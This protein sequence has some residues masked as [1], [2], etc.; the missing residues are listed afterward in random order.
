MIRVLDSFV[1]DKIAAGEVIEKPLSIVKELIENSIDA[2]STSIIVEIRNGGKSYIRITDNGS[3]IEADELETAFLR[4][5][6]GKISSIADLDSLNTLGFR[7][8]AL[9]S[10]S[11]VSRVTVVTK[12]EAALTGRKL[13][14]HGGRTIEVSDIG[15]NTGTTMIIEDVFYN[16][17]ARRKFMGSDAREATSIIDLV[18]KL[19]IYYADI[20]FMLINNGATILNTPG[21]G[22]YLSAITSIYKER[23]FSDLIEISN[24]TVHGF[25][26]DPATTKTNRKGQIF[27]VN[28]RI[29]SSRVIEKGIERGY[30]SRIFSGYP[31]AVLFLEVSPD[32]IDVN[33]HPGKREIKFLDEN[34]VVDKIASAIREVMD[35]GSSVA[36][37]EIRKPSAEPEVDTEPVIKSETRTE[38]IIKPESVS[39]PEPVITEPR[40]SIRD[41]LGNGGNE[42]QRDGGTEG[43]EIAISKAT[44]RPFDFDELRYAGYIFNSYIITEARDVIYMIDQHAAHERV[45]YE[46]LVKEYNGENHTPQPILTPYIIEVSPLV[47]NQERGW[48]DR[49]RQ[50]GYDIEDFGENTFVIRGIPV[51]MTVAEADD[52]IRAFVDNIG[53]L[54]SNYTVIDKLI[55]KSCKSAV[56][57]NNRLSELEIK[58]LLDMLSKC[59]N[60]FCCPHGRPTFIKMTRYEVERAFRRV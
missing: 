14:M 33:I 50:I 32:T 28:G 20:R 13:V 38:S 46:K 10:I 3:G 39:K 60:P 54:N 18:Q 48:M 27:F 25:I 37:L 57:A 35:K 51:Y 2:G 22:N 36:K 45:F 49:V 5:A 19:A 21:N 34:I 43:C 26:S 1:A 47:Y 55:M 6:T 23:E 44:S 15:A 58:S 41:F 8:E 9:A 4:H 29:V 11:A 31:V 42:V 40:I 56:K 7:G 30:G 24:D 17:P 12:T 59:D 52:F 16:T 53:D